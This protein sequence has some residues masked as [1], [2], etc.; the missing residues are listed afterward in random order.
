[1][2]LGQAI[3]RLL[4]VAGTVAGAALTPATAGP[5]LLFEAQS[6]KVLFSEDPDH[7]WFPA[8]LTKIMTAYITFEALKSGKVKPDQKVTVSEK[9]N[10]QAP[11]KIGLPVGAEITVEL[12]LQAVIVKSANDASMML[13]EAIAG[14]EEAFV[15]LMNDKARR[16]GMTRTVFVNPN[17]LPA[18]EQVTTARDL[19]RLT[20][21]ALRDF[22]EHTAMWAQPEVVVG[23]KTMKN[24]NALLR[25]FEGADGIKTGF[26]CDSGFNLVASA[27]R[28]G[29]KLVAVVLGDSN[30]RDRNVRAASLLDH[31]FQTWDWKQ[32][33]NSRTIESLPFDPE[34]KGAQSVRKTVETWSCGNRKRPVIARKKKGQPVAAAGSKDKAGAAKD[35]KAKAK[36][37]PKAAPK[38][39]KAASAPAASAGQNTQRAAKAATPAQ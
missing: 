6:G 22:P 20:R 27:T 8:S 16:L 39:S 32:M 33:F 36:P 34:A 30:G 38:T 31:G 24:S 18:A 23:K 17:G 2:R 9:A 14:S 21:A 37:A 26:I 12:A 29:R 5:A 35:A 28:D 19:A 13:A 11:S 15:A 1:M 4:V 10:T 3:L 25:T 7:L